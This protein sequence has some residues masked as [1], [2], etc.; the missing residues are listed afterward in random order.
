MHMFHTT[1]ECIMWE[2][3]KQ[4]GI[5]TTAAFDSSLRLD[6]IQTYTIPGTRVTRHPVKRLKNQKHFVSA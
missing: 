4:N 6:N 3:S 2:K 5:I 1:D